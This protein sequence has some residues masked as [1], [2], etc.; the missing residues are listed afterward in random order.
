MELTW[1]GR[2]QQKGYELGEQAGLER[3]REQ[4]RVQGLEQGRVQGARQVALDLLEKRF[5]SLSTK[6]VRK[7][8]AIEDLEDL[9]RL[10]ERLLQARSLRDLDLD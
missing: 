6:T 4:G 7:V 3:G 8:E 5:G 9:L 2:I 1:A 10:S